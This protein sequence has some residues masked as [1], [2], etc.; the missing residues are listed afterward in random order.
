MEL[1]FKNNLLDH[2]KGTLIT[3]SCLEKKSLS[4]IIDLH[5]LLLYLRPKIKFTIEHNL[6]ELPFLD[7]LF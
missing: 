7:I 3:I 5:N 1:Q 2:G 6:K 4:N